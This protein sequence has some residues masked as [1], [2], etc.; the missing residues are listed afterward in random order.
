METL[1]IGMA[2]LVILPLPVFTLGYIIYRIIRNRRNQCNRMST[3]SIP[4]IHSIT[5]KVRK[6]DPEFK[7]VQWS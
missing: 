6:K 1:L 7:Y 4:V 5:P 3:C 2:I